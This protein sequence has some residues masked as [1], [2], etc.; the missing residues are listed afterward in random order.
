MKTPMESRKCPPE[1]TVGPGTGTP[2]PHPKDSVRAEVRIDAVRSQCSVGSWFWFLWA[3]ILYSVFL[4]R[5]A[6]Q[7]EV[8]LR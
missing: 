1:L 6:V 8:G 3:G 2:F 4:P 5:F 7:M